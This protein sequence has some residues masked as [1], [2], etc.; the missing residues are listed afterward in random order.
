MAFAAEPSPS[1]ADV[2]PAWAYPVDPPGLPSP[3]DDGT[4]RHVPDSAVGYTLS[5]VRDG[6]L[7][8]DWHPADH[9]AMPEIVAHGRKPA[10]MACGYCHRA[11]GTGGPENASLAGLPAAYIIQQVLDFQSGARTTALPER[12]P[13]K[14]MI[15]LSKPIATAEIE[16]AAAYFSS[17]K[18][19]ANIQVI[20]T[21]NVP[22]TGVHGWHLVDL[23]NGKKEA[24]G[25][26]II[27]VPDDMEQFVSRDSRA[28]FTAYVPTGSIQKGKELAVTG[29]G[30]RTVP[31]ATC[32]GPDLRGLGP[33]PGLAG[34]SPSYLMRQLYEFKH[35]G[36]TGAV[37]ARMRP[38]VDHLTEEDMIDLSAYAA[39]L[40]P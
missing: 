28:R 21:D 14:N 23:H 16:E 34:R 24:I 6:F 18:L 38:T 13:Q 5:Q 4:L 3:V 29:G 19:K 17:L 31:C 32:H 8:P 30:G 40:E 33:I 9:P 36:R 35:D 10:V 39:S 25:Q 7:S 2:P 37:A 12:A 22:E 26:R 11:E 20:E 27:E 15:A 1:A